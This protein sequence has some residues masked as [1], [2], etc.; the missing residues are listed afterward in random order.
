MPP[1]F[2]RSRALW[3]ETKRPQPN[4][5]S[6]LCA[7][8]SAVLYELQPIRFSAINWGRLI[9]TGSRIV[10]GF[11]HAICCLPGL[12]RIVASLA[13]QRKWTVA[14][15]VVYYLAVRWIHD[16]LEAGPI[17][18]MV[19]S[20]FA[21]FT[22]GL[23]DSGNQDGLSAYSVFNRGFER[24]MGSVDADALLAQHIGLGPGAVLPV[25]PAE[26]P[27]R[28]RPGPRRDELRIAE[29]DNDNHQD[30]DNNNNAEPV[31]PPNNNNTRARKSGKKAR[32]RN[33]EQ[34]RE[35]QRQREAAM[36]IGA[37]GGESQEEMMAMQRLIENQIENENNQ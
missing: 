20:L 4:A 14:G 27:R 6:R 16:V 32:R 35:I 18:L 21:I 22:I 8:L 19:T 37:G 2:R 1:G 13:W 17:V 33:L 15:V 25:A 31:P 10:K 28:Q 7:V 30:D 26:A 12:V 3:D 23:S 9:S 36:A 11:W 5:S 29:A 24:L 34:R